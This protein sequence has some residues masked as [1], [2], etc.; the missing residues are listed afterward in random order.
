MHALLSRLVTSSNLRELGFVDVEE[1]CSIV[2]RAVAE[3]DAGAMRAAIV[4]AQWV[5]LSKEFGI[6]TAIPETNSISSKYVNE[7]GI[8]AFWAEIERTASL[9]L[10]RIAR[11]ILDGVR[12]MY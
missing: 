9:S 12:L 7:S 3:H 5:V 11:R 6:P 2:H 8:T 1:C 4:L 10:L